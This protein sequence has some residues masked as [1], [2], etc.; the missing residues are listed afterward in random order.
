MV[1]SDIRTVEGSVQILNASS[2]RGDDRAVKT[3]TDWRKKVVDLAKSQA[4]QG[5]N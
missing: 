1:T 3:P 5:D 4:E 2:F